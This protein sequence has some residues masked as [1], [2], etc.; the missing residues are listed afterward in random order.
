[1]KHLLPM[2]VL[3]LAGHAAI[4]QD[5]QSALIGKWR[6][7]EAKTLADM[8][9]HPEIPEKSRKFF[10]HRFFGRLVNV[11]EKG[12]AASYFIE[13]QG[14]PLEYY[15]YTITEVGANYLKIQYK[16]KITDTML[17]EQLFFEGDCYYV[18]IT[19]SQFREYFCRV[20]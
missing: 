9:K 3:C 20:N 17:E 13:D 8:H 1:M 10:E 14:K 6:S 19:K 18:Y 2:I 12:R 7:D 15:P 11:I 5:L 4:A 16:S